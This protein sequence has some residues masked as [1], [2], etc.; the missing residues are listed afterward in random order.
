[1]C[2]IW[3]EIFKDKQKEKLRNYSPICAM[4]GREISLNL[5]IHT[6]FASVDFT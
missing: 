3:L 4:M 6:L 1:M 2:I 5:V